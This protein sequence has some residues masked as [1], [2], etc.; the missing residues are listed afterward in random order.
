MKEYVVGRNEAGKRLDKLLLKVLNQAPSSFVYKMLRKK[1]IKLNEKKA[2]GNELLTEGDRIQIYLSDETFAKFHA[3]SAAYGD[4]KLDV[5]SQDH[6]DKKKRRELKPSDILYEDADVMIMN[7]PAGVL[8]QKAAQEDDSINE[9]MIRYLLAQGKLTR[10]QLETYT[11]SVC[12]RLDRNTSGIVMAGISLSGSQ[13][14]SR[15]LK[16]RSLNKYYL[17]LVAG[18]IEE[19]ETHTAYLKKDERTNTVVVSRDQFERE[20]IQNVQSSQ[21]GRMIGTDRESN[22]LENATQSVHDGQRIVTEYRP[23]YTNQDYTLLEV[24]L[25][26]G[27][28]HQIRAHLAYLNHP[29]IGDAKYGKKRLNQEFRQS[30]GIQNQCLHAWRVE[31]PEN[32][33]LQTAGRQWS[34]PLPGKMNLAYKQIFDVDI[35]AGFH[36]DHSK[37][38]N[39][40]IN[41]DDES[42]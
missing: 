14:L 30:F 33:T 40:D 26:T 36:T 31:F 9:Q 22:A 10:E 32:T 35:N 25:I 3:D 28:T 42:N 6:T 15:M 11:P 37:N 41:I 18:R 8:S 34:A 12:N 5:L 21:G 39:V 24:H 1:N 4:G 19:A 17:A 7:K 16:S 13:E 27:K 23:L 29:I 38:Q 2:D 20:N